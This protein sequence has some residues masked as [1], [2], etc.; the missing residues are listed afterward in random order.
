MS[1]QEDIFRM[2]QLAG[3]ISA[4]VVLTEKADVNS[5]VRAKMNDF[6]GKLLETAAKDLSV[7]S[8][9]IDGIELKKL[10]EKSLTMIADIRVLVGH[11]AK[12]KQKY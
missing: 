2:R 9:H 1:G 12:L 3:L 5:I 4:E 6:L 10:D 7:V 8:N 11:L